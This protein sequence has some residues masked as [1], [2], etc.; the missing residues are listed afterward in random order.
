M[1]ATK[2][3]LVQLL[4]TALITVGAAGCHF[5]ASVHSNPGGVTHPATPDKTTTTVHP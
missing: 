3:R 2:K 4:A 5:G 1:T